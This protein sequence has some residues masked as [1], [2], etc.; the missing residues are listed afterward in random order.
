MEVEA[1]H[2]A[3]QGSTVEELKELFVSAGYQGYEIHGDRQAIT[4]VRSTT[5]RPPTGNPTFRLVTP[6]LRIPASRSRR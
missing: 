3:R 2:L 5:W 4:L 6:G 1:E